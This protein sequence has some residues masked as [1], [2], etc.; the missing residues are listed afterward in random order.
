MVAASSAHPRGLPP[1][2]SVTLAV[3]MTLAQQGAAQIEL[4]RGPGP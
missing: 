2:T 3:S 1:L 4:H